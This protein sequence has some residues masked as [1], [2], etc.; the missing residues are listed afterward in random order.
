M[1][2]GNARE[3]NSYA[4]IIAGAG[5]LVIMGA[6][7]LAR[8]GYTLILPRMTAALD[9]SETGAGGIAT[10]N[11]IGYLLFSLAGGV[12]ATKYSPRV[13]IAV[14]LAITGA[15]LC[16]AGLSQDLPTAAFW[17]FFAG[18]GG[19]AN[20]PMMGLVSAW[21]SSK[22]RGL[23]SGIIVSGS[24]FALL[25]TGM[26]LPPVM[27]AHPTAGWRHA[28][29]L[30]GAATLLIAIVAIL[31]LRDSPAGTQ[32]PARGRKKQRVKIVRLHR[33][34][35]LA[36]LYMLF[37][38]SYVIFATFFARYLSLEA[39]LSERTVGGLWS[40]IGGVS[41]AS[42]F[43]WG[44]VSDKFGRRVAF[45]CI[46]ALQ[47]ATYLIFALWQAMPGYV[48]ATLLFALTAWSIP[49]VM[50]AAVGDAFGPA[51]APAVFGFVTLI[52][53]VGQSL[54]PVI[55]GAVADLAGTYKSAFLLA[56]AAALLGVPVS[57]LIKITHV[58]QTDLDSH[59]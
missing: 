8:F 50:G 28:W 48:L 22:R 57:L 51:A 38:F 58:S 26:I 13:V 4:W 7:G 1:P 30:L 31:V 37:G 49:A 44:I 40:L 39:M 21:F 6:I 55:A 54:G 59:A 33:A 16:G 35:P 32:R 17:R 25:L 11:M 23:A 14:S 42:G 56:A 46:F 5:V 27:T 2:D 12:L 45:A 43:L 9:M 41:I 3:N 47:G 18:A 24:S 29:Y 36:G 53:G 20:V 10:V 15:A 34:W 19:G 52:F